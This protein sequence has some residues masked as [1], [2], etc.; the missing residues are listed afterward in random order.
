MVILGLS[1]IVVGFV[2]VA[3]TIRVM[4]SS[5]VSPDPSKPPPKLVDK[6]PFR[7]SR[8]PIYISFALLYI[9]IS[10][11][12]NAFWPLITLII[13]L[14]VIDRGVILREEKFLEKKFGAEYVRYK[15]KVRRWL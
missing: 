11:A 9:G 7:Y 15:T 4:R 5:G 3:F 10:V 6:G 1:L 13:A 8:N 2:L 14:I 12:L